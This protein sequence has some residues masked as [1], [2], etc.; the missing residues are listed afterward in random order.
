MD[1]RSPISLDYSS[2]SESSIRVRSEQRS[3]ELS[4]TL[5]LS[6][7]DSRP[8]VRAEDE[9]GVYVL[10][11]R[12]SVELHVSPVDQPVEE[13]MYCSVVAEG[14]VSAPLEAAR[15]YGD[16]EVQ[17]WLEAN[18]VSLLYAKIRSY[19][20]YLTAMSSF[21]AYAIPTIDPYA[22]LAGLSEEEGTAE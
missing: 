18:A 14:G 20:E 19:V 22:F 8:L 6:R 16:D 7:P 1:F 21:G 2:I 11:Y 15:S 10:D 13:M 12:L 17:L 9:R 3:H 5:S 4:Y